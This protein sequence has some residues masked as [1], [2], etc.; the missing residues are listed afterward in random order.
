ML[1]KLKSKFLLFLIL[2]FSTN[3]CSAIEGFGDPNQA[4]SKTV[5]KGGINESVQTQ[6]LTGIGVVGL[7]YVHRKGYPSYIEEIYPSSPAENAGI[8]RS[9]FIYSIDGV[10]TINL[11][12]EQVH[13]LLSGPPGTTVKLGIKRGPSIYTVNVSRVDLATLSSYVQNEYLSGPIAV[14]FDLKEIFGY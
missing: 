8:R 6:N 2:F 1:T 13:N 7:K 11:G 10:K 4:P 9:D 5:L 12:S 3:I 14:P